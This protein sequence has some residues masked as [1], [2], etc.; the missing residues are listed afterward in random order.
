M[1]TFGPLWKTN[2]REFMK[3]NST[4]RQSPSGWLKYK[5]CLISLA[6]SLQ[7]TACVT[8]N[9][10][11][12]IASFQQSVN[13]SSAAMGEYYANVN[14]FERLLYL[15]DAALHPDQ[16]VF[17]QNANKPT[18]LAGQSFTA[19]AIRARMASLTLLAT[20]G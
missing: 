20:F 19:E 4:F 9:F 10:T 1:S 16:G 3:Q 8:T 12:P 6:I 7:P 18:P 14:E 15:H 17:W 11:K 5:W 13:T 2:R